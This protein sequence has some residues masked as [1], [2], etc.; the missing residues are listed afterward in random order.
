MTGHL[1]EASVLP[2]EIEDLLDGPFG[3]F[4]AGTDRIVRVEV[5]LAEF[6]LEAEVAFLLLLSQ[7]GDASSDI[8]LVGEG[9]GVRGRGVVTG[10]LVGSDLCLTFGDEPG[11]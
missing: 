6:D 4:A 2:K 8:G 7:H 10:K 9:G 11:E 5:R 3:D 1:C